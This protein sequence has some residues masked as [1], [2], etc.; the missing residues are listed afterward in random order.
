[1][2][3]TIH[4][5][6]MTRDEILAALVKRDGLV[7]AH[8]KCTRPLDF[9]GTGGDEVT[10]DH[11]MPQEWCYKN[12]WTYEEVW[13]LSNLRLAHKSC[14]AKKGNIV[15][16]EDGTLPERKHKNLVQRRAEKAQRPEV[17]TACNAGRKLGPDDVCAACRSG[18]LPLRWNRAEEMPSHECDHELFWCQKCFFEP[19]LRRSAAEIILTRE[20][21]E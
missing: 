19:E 2:T 17:C 11:W 15:P 6:K 13:A 12:N 8:P 14:N 10:I 4:R 21:G 3:E 7:C 9:A 16:N 5:T 1:M 18:P 20:G